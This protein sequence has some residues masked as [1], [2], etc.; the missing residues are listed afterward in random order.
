VVEPQVKSRLALLG[1]EPIGSTTA[2]FARYID[3]E[4]TKYARI[5]KDANIKAE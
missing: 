4:M 1:F 3:D 2:Y 5:I